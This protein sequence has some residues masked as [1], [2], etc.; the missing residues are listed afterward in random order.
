MAKFKELL[1]ETEKS[2][3]QIEK[4]PF[5]RFALGP[6]MIW[7]GLRSKGMN[8]W[9]RRVLVAGG[10]YQI[11]YAWDEYRKLANAVQTGPKET[12]AILQKN[13]LYEGGPLGH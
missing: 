3:S 13:T 8:K 4:R 2:F 11:I 12:F 6:F 9:P 5:D 1:I 7:F 10:I